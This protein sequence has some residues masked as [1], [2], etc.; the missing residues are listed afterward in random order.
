MVRG[1]IQ[2]YNHV[3]HQHIEE[4]FFDLQ[5]GSISIDHPWKQDRFYRIQAM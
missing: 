1:G 4:F 3:T 2:G 5:T